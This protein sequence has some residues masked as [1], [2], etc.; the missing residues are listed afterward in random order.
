[1]IKYN[2]KLEKLNKEKILTEKKKVD[3]LEIKD[4][5]NKFSELFDLNKP[6]GELIIKKY[7]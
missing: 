7:F 6:E 1:L 4:I 5:K 2:T 3:L